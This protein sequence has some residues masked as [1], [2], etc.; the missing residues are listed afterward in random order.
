MPVRRTDSASEGCVS[1]LN[2]ST[3]IK[4]RLRYSGLDAATQNLSRTACCFAFFGLLRSSEFTTKH[5]RSFSPE[6]HTILYRD[7]SINADSSV[8]LH[9]RHSKAGFQPVSDSSSNSPFGVPCPCLYE[10]PSPA[11]SPNFT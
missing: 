3:G 5:L 7:I 2:H 8:T 10:L 4:T 1:P 9:L 11:R 6:E